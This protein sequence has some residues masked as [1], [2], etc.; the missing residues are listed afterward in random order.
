MLGLSFQPHFLTQLKMR[1][2][3]LVWLWKGKK[4]FLLDSK[5][6][7]NAC[8]LVCKCWLAL[9]RLSR[10]TSVSA[11]RA[12]LTFLLLRSTASPP[13]LFLG[14]L[15]ICK[16]LFGWKVCSQRRTNQE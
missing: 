11:E 10:T 16:W 15:Y 7:R 9:E 14:D 12:D 8:S 2:S 1:E 5:H 3:K 13:L 4:V 6:S